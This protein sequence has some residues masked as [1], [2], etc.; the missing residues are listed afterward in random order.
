MIAARQFLASVLAFALCLS[1]SSGAWGALS[2]GP[3]I[4]QKQAATRLVGPRSLAA[5]LSAKALRS[6]KASPGALKASAIFRPAPAAA[7]PASA[8]GSLRALAAAGVPSRN[9]SARI[10]KLYDNSAASQGSESESESSEV[11]QWLSPDWVQAMI[12]RTQATDPDT[13]RLRDIVQ[14]QGFRATALNQAVISGHNDKYTVEIPLGPVLDQKQSGTCWLFAGVKSISEGLDFEV[15]Y[16]HFFNMLEKANTFLEEVRA[17]VYR[18]G[19]KAK[20]S[21]AELREIVT[22]KLD[23]GGFYEYFKFLVS[24]WGLIP[25]GA[26][27][28][29]SKMAM[30]ASKSFEATATLISELQDDLA[31]TTAELM[32]NA[33]RHKAGKAPDTSRRIKEKGMQRVGGILVTHLGVPPVEGFNFRFDGPTKAVGRTQVTPAMNIQL[34]PQQFARKVVR[35]NPKDY[36]VVGSFPG[37]KTGKV[38]KLKKSSIGVPQPGKTKFDVRFMNVAPERFEGVTAAAVKGGQPVWFAADV[39]RDVDFQSGI[40]HPRIFDRASI[41]NFPEAERAA[42]LSRKEMSYFN[43]ISPNHAMVI[44]GYDRPDPKKPVVKFQVLNSWGS[45]VGSSGVFH[46]YREWFHKNVF[47]VIVHKRFLTRNEKKAWSGR[48]KLI[49]DERDWY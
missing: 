10:S 27:G 29:A 4:P 3:R 33:R 36:I 17:K 5:P 28:L 22:P 21:K 14:S 11:G 35:Y 7:Q 32:A 9:P 15:A 19:P 25:K 6:L 26:T 49:K 1:S 8:A 30:G 39:L 42:K 20:L 12:A 40:M 37:L 38:Y 48:A 45:E 46:L 13:L 2:E 31:K 23:D 44:S 34:T 41:Y 24:K 18:R 47:E 43:R 16:L